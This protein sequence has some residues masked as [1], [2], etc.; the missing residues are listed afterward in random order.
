MRPDTTRYEKIR[1]DTARYY[2]MRRDECGCQQNGAHKRR[3]AKKPR[4]LVVESVVAEGGHVPAIPGAFV[5]RVSGQCVQHIDYALLNQPKQP[6]RMT[7][8]TLRSENTGE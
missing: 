4:L 7:K 6:K 3:E 1:C 8:T 5:R 2:E